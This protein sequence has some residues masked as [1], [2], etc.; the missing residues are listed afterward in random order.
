MFQYEPNE[1]RTTKDVKSNNV[2]QDDEQHNVTL[3]QQNHERKNHL[4]I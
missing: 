2:A 4:F 1:H 3:R